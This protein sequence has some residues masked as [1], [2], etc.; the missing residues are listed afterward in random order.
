MKNFFASFIHSLAVSLLILLTVLGVIFV[1]LNS[2]TF[3][4][5]ILE[6]QNSYS[7][8]KGTIA[9]YLSASDQLPV[10]LSDEQLTRIV[11]TAFSD[12]ELEQITNTTADDFYA[13]MKGQKSEFA[14]NLDMSAKKPDIKAETATV[15]T[16]YIDGLPECTNAQIARME[17]SDI[18]K[19][20]CRP[21]LEFGVVLDPNQ[22]AEDIVSQLPDN[23]SASIPDNLKNIPNVYSKIYQGFISLIVI[24]VLLFLLALLMMWR[25]KRKYFRW[26]GIGLI[27]N[28]IPLL[29][30][31][32]FSPRYFDS[33]LS[34]V[35]SQYQDIPVST[36]ELLQ[37]VFSEF[38]RQINNSF[39]V[40]SVFFSVF[41]FVVLF[42]SY[43][44][45]KSQPKK[46]L[47]LGL[48]R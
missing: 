42:S 7:K 9:T 2:P 23:Y 33:E 48:V 5:N 38:Y 17:Q 12:S 3:L 45:K 29:V 41:G 13:W 46:L 14:F 27:I 25:D 37:G 20:D 39:Y 15:L 30:V 22:M 10:N 6:S 28:G 4:T 21:A 8:V 1:K 36:R 40:V 44:F 24:M 18:T 32:Y 31:A 47:D 16:E 19:L 26:L 35:I 34:Q 43:F 11:G